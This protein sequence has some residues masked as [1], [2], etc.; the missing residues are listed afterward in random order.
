MA[1]KKYPH[2]FMDAKGNE[3]HHFKD[4]RSEIYLTAQKSEYDDWIE[5]TDQSDVAVNR[6]RYLPHIDSPPRHLMTRDEDDD[7][8]PG[9]DDLEV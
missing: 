9:I 5:V 1:K 4:G 2:V 6:K 3:H 8:T 7:A